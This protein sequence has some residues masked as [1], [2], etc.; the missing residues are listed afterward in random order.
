M[1]SLPLLVKCNRAAPSA[2]QQGSRLLDT[3]TVCW[4]Q[5]SCSS[6]QCL[7]R[8]AE[9]ALPSTPAQGAEAGCVTCGRDL[10]G[11][12]VRGI[13]VEVQCV[14]QNRKKGRT[15]TRAETVGVAID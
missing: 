4:L 14:E 11:W 5:C 9:C 3:H 6:Q 15:I 10:L 13:N 8:R 7:L 1:L 12:K 2:Q